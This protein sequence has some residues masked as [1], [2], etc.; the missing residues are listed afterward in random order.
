[1]EVINFGQGVK[2]EIDTYTKPQE[3]Q[4]L[5]DNKEQKNKIE[6]DNKKDEYSE[7]DIKKAVEKLNKFLEDDNTHAE[8]IVHDKFGDVMIKIIDDKTK[9]VVMEV[10]PK[11]I[12]DLVAKLCESVGVVFDKKA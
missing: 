1:M 10:P 3:I 5:E 4:K 7:K 6:I 2:A 12:L 11:K 9:E 8:Y